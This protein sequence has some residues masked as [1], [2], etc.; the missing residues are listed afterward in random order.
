MAGVKLQGPLLVAA[1]RA[2]PTG[3]GEWTVLNSRPPAMELCCFCG[4]DIRSHLP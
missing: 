2:C 1:L 4:A 3:V